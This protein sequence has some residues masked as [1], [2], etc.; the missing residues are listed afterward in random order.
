LVV[1]SA[2]GIC[3]LAWAGCSESS[4][5]GPTGTVVGKVTY[6]GNP[7]PAGTTVT[8]VNEENGMAAVGQVAANGTYTLLMRGERKVLTGPYRIAIGPAQV[9]VD[10]SSDPKAYEA[11]MT[12][13]GRMAETAASFPEKYK[14]AETSGLTY[15]VQPS[16]NIHDIELTDEKE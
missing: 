1:A 15:V 3:L 5:P 9:S 8:F 11:I 12:G 4:L 7:V 2:L 13:Q 16:A 10:P 14:T 6:K